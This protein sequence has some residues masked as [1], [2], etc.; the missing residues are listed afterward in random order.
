MTTPASRPAAAP[1]NG[2][3]SENGHGPD[4]AET[5]ASRADTLSGIAAAGAPAG[6]GGSAT[7]T[8][9]A[10]APASVASTTPAA[11]PGAAPAAAPAHPQPHA[12]HRTA[13]DPAIFAA[14][15]PK[16]KRRGLL[17]LFPILLIALAAAALMAYRYWYE[18]TYFVST[19]NASVTGDLVQVGSL[20]AGRIVATRAD[21][22]ASVR[23]GQEIAVVAMPQEVGG[24]TPGGA[25]RM[26][27]TGNADTLVSVVAPLT[28]V[29]AARTGYIGGTVAAG[30]PIYA[31]V[32]PRQVWVKANI[33]E[34][35]AWRVAVG[36]PVS[37]HVDALNADFSG[38]VEAI[39]PAS[40]ATFSL[41]PSGNVSGNFTK[42]TQYVPVKIS[43][44]AGNTVLPLGTSVEVRI[45]VR[46]PTEEYP[47]PWRP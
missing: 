43:V 13:V 47:M 39:T 17:L 24:T 34:G 22:G 42:V 16:R 38:R 33:E 18:S 19:D 29:V 36:Q 15:R 41:L 6:G 45:Q 7:A 30:Q 2:H 40:A 21:V 9:P 31:L 10:S 25:P 5:A 37:V 32:D 27:V 8:A 23:Q 20:N 11:A 28:G 44:D 26:G 4:T 14:S 12:R 46:Q 3:A 35:S 1:T